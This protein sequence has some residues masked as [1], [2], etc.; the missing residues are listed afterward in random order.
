MSIERRGSSWEVASGALNL[1]SGPSEVDRGCGGFKR[2]VHLDLVGLHTHIGT[3][4]LEP[5]AYGDACR[6]TRTFGKNRAAC[7]NTAWEALVHRHRRKASH[8][9]N[10]LKGQY[11]ETAHHASPSFRAVRRR[12]RTRLC[13]RLRTIHPPNGPG[14]GA[15]GGRAPRRTAAGYLVHDGSSRAS[16]KPDAQPRAESRRPGV[17]TLLFTSFWYDPRG[18]AGWRKNARHRRADRALRSRCA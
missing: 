11:F 17:E 13:S 6:K 4:V 18:H 10:S 16:G 7:P 2:A 1:D 5:S 12:G 14:L 3:Y 8:R 15:R 9:P